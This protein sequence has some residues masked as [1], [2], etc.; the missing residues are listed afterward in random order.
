MDKN[1]II[2]NN[3]SKDVSNF[4]LLFS[5]MK[6]SKKLLSEYEK[7]I[8]EYYKAIYG[9]NK[10]LKEINCNFLVEDNF[11]ASIRN[12]PIFKFG[13]AIKRAVEV[14]IK[15]V[16]SI[17]NDQNIFDGFRNSISKLS[18]IL[19]ESSIQL[20]N[21][22]FFENIHPIINSLNESY[23]DIESKVIDKYIR[24]KYNK[25]LIELNNETLE[26]NIED[27]KYLEKTFLDFE[28]DKR[29]GFFSNIKN[30]ENKTVEVFNG[31]KKTIENIIIS[32]KNKGSEYLNILENEIKVVQNK[33]E[34]E[35]KDEKLLEEELGLKDN[36]DKFKYKIKI[37]NYPKI[38]V[39]DNTK[40]N[41]QKTKIDVNSFQDNEFILNDEDIYNIVSTI[42]SYDFKMLIKTDYNL[43]IEKEKLKVI[44][45]SEKLLPLN[46]NNTPLETITEEEINKL[47]ELVNDKNNMIK[48]F[49]FLNNYRTTGRYELTEKTFD[50][51]KNIFNKAQD[52]LLNNKDRLLEKLIII[53]SQTFYLKKNEKQFFLQYAI[54]KHELFK[55]EE[56]WKSHLKD[57]IDEE[58][59]R[60][61]RGIKNNSIEYNNEVKEKKIKDIIS[62]KLIPFSDY[63]VGFETPKEMILNII[64][65]IIDKYN[66]E[67]TK[68][69]ILSLIE[70]KQ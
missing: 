24:Q 36:I 37:I 56:F 33:T 46:I 32:L 70:H 15:N 52:Y 60:F 61:E 69:I 64:N 57:I 42:Y 63:M 23:S 13:K 50:I 65:P 19:Q 4:F 26:K 62:S 1:S 51:I 27:A 48:F 22:S 9:Y 8:K 35:N 20:D 58:I 67:D 59:L 38:K 2:S 29:I 12:S 34:L 3:S 28:E 30:L 7:Y 6:E 14:Y 40:N 55:K 45:L 43:D 68:I 16:F 47:Y 31:L 25:H 44:K 18:N 17:I 21:K 5:N 39:E 49:F 53:L 41:N 54:N 66:L 11:K 10:Q